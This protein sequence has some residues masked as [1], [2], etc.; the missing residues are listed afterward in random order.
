AALPADDD[1]TVRPDRVR[2]DRLA[3]R[4]IELFE[5][6]A[7]ELH[8]HAR[9]VRGGARPPV[10]ARRNGGVQLLPREV[11]GRSAGQHDCRR[12]LARGAAGGW[13]WHF[14]FLGAGFMLLETKSIVQF[15]LLWGSTWSSASLAIASVLVMALASALVV[16][17]V[18]I[19][20]RTIVAA[21]LL[22][23]VGVNY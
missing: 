22:A 16:S 2:A 7:R 11:A 13:S 3:D 19:R 4:A 1:H 10:A 12:L 9:I 21:A 15:A 23:L 14:F 5:R 18:E 20:R 17:R 6:A 8:V